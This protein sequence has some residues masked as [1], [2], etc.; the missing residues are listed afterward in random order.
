[1]LAA[2]RR[3][4]SQWGSQQAMGPR[5]GA[6]L[7]QPLEVL[8]D[9]SSVAVV[10]ASDDPTKWGHILARRALESSGARPVV[11]VNRSG[12]DVLG[13][14]THLSLVA[15]H[16]AGA[17][18]DLAVLCVP[19]AG[20]VEA[21]HDA[22][23]AGAR[24]LVVITAGLSEHD[25]AGAR[26]EQAALL[27]ARA[28]GV[29]LVG[30]NCLGVV[31]TGTS[32]QLS[33]A[34]LPPGDVTVLS[35][36]GNVVLDLAA[37]LED[38]GLGVARFVS[39]GNQADVSVVDLM[40]SCVAH[41]GT[42]AVAMYAEDVVDGRAF[43]AAARALVDAGKPV[44][45]LAPG[46][47]EAAVRG[48][49]SHTG[50]LTSASQ[51]VDAACAAAGIHRVDNPTQMA[52]L[53]AALLADRRMRSGRVAVVTDGGGHGAIAADTLAAAGLETRVLD[54]GVQTGLRLAL[55]KGATVTNPVDLAG[56]GDRDP[57]AYARGVAALL[58]ADDVDA[59]LLTGYFGGYSTGATNL[60]EP[61]TEAARTIGAAA[62]EWHKP[63]VV[64]TIFPD[65]PSARILADA[66]IPVHRDIDRA[67]AVLAALVTR[68]AAEPEALP[69]PA[70]PLSDTS[71][72][73]ARALL[74]AEG[75]GF[76]PS[77]TVHS[78]DELRAALADPDL[79]HPLVLKAVG[80]LHKSDAGGVVLGLADAGATEAAYLALVARL[81]P[82][83]VSVEVMAD[84]DAGVELIVGCLRDPRFG[85]VLM[86]GLGGVFAEVL[87][88][89][90]VALAPVSPDGARTLLL[91]LRG[92]A[93]LHG[94]RGRAPVD[95]DAL[96]DLVS[97]VS[98]VA[99]AHPELAEL[100]VNPVLASATG[101]LA[102][103]ARAV[104][105]APQAPS[106]SRR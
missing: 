36:S 38:R 8:F 65:S 61:E 63:V 64:Q 11:L 7:R 66:A 25:D 79:T 70:T 59:V 3:Q 18:V 97:R 34:V 48:A 51:V 58:A 85:P 15:A 10:G 83:A 99:A 89:T 49:R 104:R 12:R 26:V 42:R 4:A 56:A 24:S 87:G 69:A 62:T 95:L 35:Q 90:A 73:A 5:A 20:L 86:V 55:G 77:R 53:L 52:D 84:L 44:V 100:E 94:V 28:A 82:P 88:D 41:E 47:S 40:E 91:S 45:L 29:V 68:E 103:D 27:I 102:L 101:A 75:V 23:D 80:S 13:R 96:A 16:A 57:L 1:M 71:Y 93:L 31:D 39:V 9:P 50:A 67:C 81:A 76:V 19:A 78:L 74:A 72:D 17:D 43:V 92:A 2:M 54:E 37:L 32:L 98:H 30:P 14:P 46:R 33:H 22:V 6:A 21:V 60:T 106:T 105:V